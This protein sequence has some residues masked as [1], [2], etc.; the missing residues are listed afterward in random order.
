M[1]LY[2]VIPL[3]TIFT[4]TKIQL[5]KQ[6]NIHNTSTELN[7]HHDIKINCFNLDL[8]CLTWLRAKMSSGIVFHKNAT[9]TK[10]Q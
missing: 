6:N 7:S 9:D 10:K 8:K 4:V 1:C 3:H 5:Q 2:K